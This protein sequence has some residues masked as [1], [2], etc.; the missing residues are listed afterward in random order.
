MSSAELYS[1][2]GLFLSMESYM[3]LGVNYYQEQLEP[4]STHRAS[5]LRSCV[6]LELEILW[7]IDRLISN[8]KFDVN[9][10]NNL[11]TEYQFLFLKG[12]LDNRHGGG[13]AMIVELLQVV[14]LLEEREVGRSTYSLEKEKVL[15][16]NFLCLIT[17]SE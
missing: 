10:C 2:K 13:A 5:G 15:G 11:L 4:R 8:S 16:K 17:S 3:F 14:P 1:P 12:R 6:F 7:A 9:F